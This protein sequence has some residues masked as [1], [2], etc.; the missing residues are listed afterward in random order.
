MAPV[1]HNGRRRSGWDV[2][3]NRARI[4]RETTDCSA[5]QT[6]AITRSTP[7]FPRSY[8]SFRNTSILAWALWAGIAT[9]PAPVAVLP[10]TDPGQGF[11]DRRSAWTLSQLRLRRTSSR[12]SWRRRP[13][14]SAAAVAATAALPTSCPSWPSSS[15]LHC[16]RGCP[17]RH[18][19]PRH[20]APPR[21]PRHHF[22]QWQ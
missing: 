15:C 2:A 4:M 10:S 21:H 3:A 6:T 14:G 19:A 16:L 13:A 11:A 9:A 5:R 20:P 12:R 18:P 1:R 22:P 8:A 17:P 7:C